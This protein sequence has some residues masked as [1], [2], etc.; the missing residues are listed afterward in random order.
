M[1]RS[2]KFWG[3][4]SRWK[5]TFWHDWQGFLAFGSLLALLIKGFSAFERLFRSFLS[6]LLIFF[7]Y[8]PE[9]IQK[10]VVGPN[11]RMMSWLQKQFFLPFSFSFRLLSFSPSFSFLFFV[12][13]NILQDV[14]YDH[15]ANW[16][17]N[18]DLFGKFAWQKGLCKPLV[19]TA[20][21]GRIYR[22]STSEYELVRVIVGRHIWNGNIN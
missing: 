19:Y 10:I 13:L 11:Y 15:L 18:P 17:A 1:P 6:K 3:F 22:F 7:K 4:G 12:V 21:R 20:R 14:S 2:E 8:S 5:R 9:N 16:Q